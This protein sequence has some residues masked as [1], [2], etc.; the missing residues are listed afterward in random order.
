M[1]RIATEMTRR[2]MKRLREKAHRLRQYEEIKGEH[3]GRF[4]MEKERL[5]RRRERLRQQA[6]DE[7]CQAFGVMRRSA[8]Y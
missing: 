3:A 1:K 4:A 8:H 7:E 6:C 5:A 2:W